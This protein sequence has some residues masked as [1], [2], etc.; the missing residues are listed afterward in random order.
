MSV[1]AYLRSR[2]PK[3]WPFFFK[4]GTKIDF[5]NSLDKFANQKNQF[6][7]TL[8]ILVF[9]APWSSLGNNNDP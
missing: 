2:D 7:Y 3:L 1:G 5:C 4:F 9:G 8:Y 6:M